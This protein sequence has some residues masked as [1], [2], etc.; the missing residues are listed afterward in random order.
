MKCPVIFLLV[1]ICFTVSIAAQNA[2]RNKISGTVTDSANAAVGEAEVRLVNAQQFVLSVTKTDVEGRYTFENVANGSYV[3]IASRSDFSPRR[4][5]VRVSGAAAEI[6]LQ[7]GVNQLNEQ[8][9]VTAE[10]GLAEDTSKIPQQI[11]VVTED[12][13]RQRAT[14]VLAQVADEET[15]VSL[16]RTSPTVGA[17]LVRGL[18][19]VGVY[20]DGVRYTNSTQRGGINTF[21]NLNEPTTLRSVEIQR[22]P[23]TAQFGSD[24]LGGN[25]QLVSRQPEFGFDRPKWSG[26]LN[27]FFSSADRSFGSNALISYGAKRFGVLGNAVARR[28]N[29]LRPGKGI[30]SHSAITRFL[31]LPSDITGSERLPDTAFTQYGGTFQFNFAPTDDRQISFRYQRSQQDGGKRYDQLLGGDGNLI[32]DLRNLML[33]F[34]YLRYFKQNVGFFDNLSATVSYNSQREERV[35]QGGQG[36]PLAAITNDKER[37]SSWGFSFFLD[38]QFAGNNFLIGG[39]YYRDKVNAPS[40][41]TDPATQTVTLVRPRVPNGATYDLGGLFVQ[42]VFEAIPKRLRLSGALRYNVGFYRSRSSASP[43]VNNRPLFPDDSAGFEDFSGRIGATVTIA[44]GLNAAFNYSRGFR[45]PNITSLG[46]L[47]LV[48]VGFQVSTTDVAG[49]GATIGTTADSTAISSGIPVSPLKSEISNN[50]DVSLRYRNRRFDANLTGYV[51]DYGN[52][53]VRQTL[54]LPPGAVGLQLGSQTIAS[55]NANG[56]V[57]V[58]ASTSPV[59]VQ[60]NFSST[61]L[62]GVEFNFDYRF[63]EDW[64]TGGNYSYVYAED[65]ATGEPPNLGGGGIP[66]QLAFLRLRYQPSGNRYWVEAYANGAGRQSRLSTLD[67]SDRR[68]GAAR[69]RA[70]IQNFFRR[71]ACVRGI[72]TPGT[73]GQCNTA[74]GILIATGETLAQVQNRL[75]PIGAVINGV[76][77]AG[78]DTAVPLFSSIPGYVLLNLRGGYRFGENHEVTVDFENIA[79]KSYRAPGWG[80]DGHGRSVTFRYQYRF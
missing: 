66:P 28:I 76:R 54:I 50:Y 18:T 51:I 67:L 71:G 48:G 72:T 17:V 47:G 10:T 12:A 1:I 38:K 6:N 29:T 26:E 34:A 80:I 55:Q 61:R 75:L 79:D 69:S 33:D 8:V 65:R 49:L 23:N 2:G 24:G 58:P 16:Q 11:N 41:N 15:G 35:N 13:I 30:D 45:A 63:L 4:E 44:R 64:T 68:T 70:Q 60:S 19:E 78:N 42:D 52:T 40:F 20:V 32:A 31:G 21:F 3:V 77:V 46:S 57:F 39:D 9:T 22:S 43:L 74:G 14:A 56:A 37:T 5:A 59:L 27:T 53:I 36:N 62:K 73:N 7:L 25:V